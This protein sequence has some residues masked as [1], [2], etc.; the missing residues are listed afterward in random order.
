MVKAK[1]SKRPQASVEEILGAGNDQPEIPSRWQKQYRQL[2][3]MRDHL[4]EK[5]GSLADQAREEQPN[6]SQHLADAA[7]DEYDMNAALAFVSAEQNALY[8]IDQA[9]AR[10]LDGSYG[11]CELTGQQIPKERLDAIPWTRFAKDAEAQLEK[12]GQIQKTA[13]GERE[14]IARA[15]TA[16]SVAQRGIN[17]KD[18]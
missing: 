5:R 15:Q 10:I 6:F 13:L 11:V 2:S 4:L 1:G 7:T 14:R 8:E 17:T 9:M 18:E 16:N 3:R 12:D